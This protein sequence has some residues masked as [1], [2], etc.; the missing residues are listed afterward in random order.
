MDAGFGS[1]SFF[2]RRGA[3]FHAAHH[4]VAVNVK[5]PYDYLACG[6]IKIVAY[7][8]SLALRDPAHMDWAYSDVVVDPVDCIFFSY[9]QRYMVLLSVSFTT[10][11]IGPPIN[12]QVCI[13][14]C[15]LKTI[16]ARHQLCPKTLH[17][18]PWCVLRYQH[19]LVPK[20]Y[21]YV[22]LICT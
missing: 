7:L 15:V 8:L 1:S 16:N 9:N 13:P 19:P 12:I 5:A 18:W 20:T 6:Q 22:I 10:G 21:C 4:T 11:N 14:A 2:P 17:Q 3:L